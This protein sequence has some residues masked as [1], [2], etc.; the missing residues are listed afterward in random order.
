ME[1]N[2]EAYAPGKDPW[3][4]VARDKERQAEIDAAVPLPIERGHPF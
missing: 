1:S 4:F 2:H 3:R